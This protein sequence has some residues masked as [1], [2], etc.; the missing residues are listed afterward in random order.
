MTSSDFRQKLLESI[1]FV[2]FQYRESY[3][4]FNIEQWLHD[5]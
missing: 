4:L 5:K 3:S 2:R 1:N